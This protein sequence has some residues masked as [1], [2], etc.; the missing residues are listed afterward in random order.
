MKLKSN[1]V[2][3]QSKWKQVVAKEIDN[4]LMQGRRESSQ[5][6]S[7]DIRK[8]GNGIMIQKWQQTGNCL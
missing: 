4:V 1:E 6:G 5:R 3:T 2:F 8:C 7:D